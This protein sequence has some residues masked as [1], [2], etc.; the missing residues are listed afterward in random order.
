[1]TASSR[2]VHKL[3]RE[4]LGVTAVPTPSERRPTPHKRSKSKRK[5]SNGLVDVSELGRQM[6]LQLVSGGARELRLYYPTQLPPGAT[7][8]SPPRAYEVKSQ[9]HRRYQAYRLVIPTGQIGEYIGFQGLG[10]KNPPI[11]RTPT[12]TRRIGSRVFR[13]YRD[14]ART[15]IVAWKSDNAVYWVSNTLSESLTERQ[16]LSIAHAARPLG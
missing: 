15:R 7:F 14:G 11:L 3:A 12:T 9:D 4:F 5:R 1:V 8:T 10:W 6:A 13:I 16:L 2:V